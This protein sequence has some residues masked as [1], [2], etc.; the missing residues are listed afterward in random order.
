MMAMNVFVLFLVILAFVTTSG[1]D[2]ALND[3]R[4]QSGSIDDSRNDDQRVKEEDLIN[5]FETDLKDSQSILKFKS[6]LAC[7]RMI[8]VALK[9]RHGRESDNKDQPIRRLGFRNSCR[10]CRMMIRKQSRNDE[11]PRYFNNG[12]WFSFSPPSL[13]KNSK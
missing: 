12:Q 10:V 8:Q 7:R 2:A 1:V 3:D 13:T 9:H 5:D 11:I 4:M 6:C